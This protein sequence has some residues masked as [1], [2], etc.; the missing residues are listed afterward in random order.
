MNRISCFFISTAALAAG[1]AAYRWNIL[2]GY[3]ADFC[4]SF[5]FVFALQGVLQLSSPH[6][7]LLVFG[8]LLGVLFEEM[9][10][11]G[12]AAGTAD[13]WDIVVYILAAA[14]AVS[15]IKGREIKDEKRTE[16]DSSNPVVGP[17]SADGRREQQQF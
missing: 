12:A 14:L 15:I 1:T 4:W 2:P 5:A 13:G 10:A 7:I 17:V 6:S 3:G 16:D 9:Q 11:V 8:S